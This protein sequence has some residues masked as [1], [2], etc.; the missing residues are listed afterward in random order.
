MA[1]SYKQFETDYGYKSPGFT[2]DNL[3][4]VT[5]RT[6]T[7][8]Y[9]PTASDSID[10]TVTELSN[11]FSITDKDNNNLG[12][13]PAI[14]LK[15]GTTYVF[16]LDTTSIT[17]NTFSPDT[18]NDA[19]PGELFNTGLSHTTSINGQNLATDTWTV[20][21]TWQQETTAYSRPVTVVVPSTTGTPLEGKQIPVV[22]SL[23]NANQSSGNA[24][25]HLNYL[26]DKIIVAPQGYSKEWNIGYSSSKA[27]DIAY[28][29]AI[30]DKLATYDNVDL[31]EITIHGQG[32][33]GQMAHQ[34]ALQTTKTNV[35]NVIIESALFNEDQYRENTNI[36]YKMALSNLGDSTA[37]SWTPVTPLT[38][39][40]VVMFHGEEDLAYP[41]N[42]GV[43]SGETILTA[44][45]TIYGWAKANGS[46][47]T[48][49]TSGTLQS[50]GGSLYSYNSGA[51][52]LY[53]YPNVAQTWEGTV[54]TS[55]QTKINEVSTPA[56]F[57]DIP[58]ATTVTEAVAQA[59]TKGLLS[60]TIPV[61]APD[62]LFYGDG[63]KLPNAAI[64]ISNPTVV[65][66]GSFSSIL[67]TGDLTSSG[68]NAAINISP[69]GTGTVNIN[70]TGGGTINNV[71]VNASNL[72]TSGEVSITPNEDVTISPQISGT[73][74]INPTAT[75][76]VNNVTIGQSVPKAGAFTTLVSTSGTLNSTT[77]G[78]TTPADAGFLQA[79]GE[80]APTTGKHL[81]NKTYVDATSMVYS[82]A[83]G[84]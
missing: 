28:I 72:T 21:Q 63:D 7:N 45:S 48:K 69:T 20:Q 74:T 38:K 42:G 83:L 53:G 31:R 58:T 35:K 9:T 41:F 81:T 12:T 54:K 25:T 5:V 34:Y 43:V 66:I 68:I 16:K 49:L 64:N 73:L 30:V 71:N 32:L 39:T 70:P 79:S 62:K 6:I 2:V 40:K 57:L 78:T 36:F 3:G 77:I 59:K 76:V 55:I 1:V 15:R 50:D 82:I 61:N 29:D 75:G 22:I 4:N 19:V 67:N 80:N 10:Y 11:N 52:S 8:T 44:A 65:G 27:D 46:N 26:T 60:F 37:V 47:E 17:F 18:N 24:I 13:N 23:H 14:S 56:S 33:G 51:V 84:V